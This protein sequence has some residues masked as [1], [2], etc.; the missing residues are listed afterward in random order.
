MLI[1]AFRTPA[2][3]LLACSLA[4]CAHLPAP[5][6]PGGACKAGLQAQVQDVLYFGIHTPHG[7]V[8]PERW[9]AFLDGTVTPRFP[10]GLTVTAADGQW[11]NAKGV[12]GREPS[13]VLTLVHPDDAASDAAVVEIAEAYKQ[14]Y[15]QEAVLR[16]RSAACVSF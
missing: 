14:R 5:G 8:T 2:L 10:Q 4:A 6:A 7:D 1:S 9:R 15:E 12:I 16:V 3:A 13:Y 11:R